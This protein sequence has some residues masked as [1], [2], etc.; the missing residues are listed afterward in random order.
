MKYIPIHLKLSFHEDK[1][2]PNANGLLSN[3]YKLVFMRSQGPY[4]VS[5]SAGESCL[6]CLMAESLPG[7]VTGRGYFNVNG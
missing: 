6:S 4:S 1:T 3:E 5:Y 2:A 7:Q